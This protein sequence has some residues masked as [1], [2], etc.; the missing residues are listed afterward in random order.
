MRK[1]AQKKQGRLLSLALVAFCQETEVSLMLV[2]VLFAFSGS[3][4][5]DVSVA[6]AVLEL[7]SSVNQSIKSVIFTHSNIFTCIV[8]CSSLTNN[9]ITCLCGLS[10]EELQTKSFAM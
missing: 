2:L 5:V 1:S 8:N 6:I 7:N 9:N 4:Y 3:H 10:S